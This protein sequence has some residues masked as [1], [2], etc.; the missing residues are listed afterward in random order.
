MVTDMKQRPN[1]KQEK[2]LA[3]QEAL[4]DAAE[5]LIA[6][7]G[8]HYVT[9]KDIVN[10]ANQKNPSVLQYHFKTMGGLLEALHLR[11][12]AQTRLHRSKLL[13]RA[14]IAKGK[15]ELRDLC[16]LMIRPALELARK[17][18]QYRAYAAAF[19]H[20]IAITG[21]SAFEVV[22]R[23]GGGSG[24]VIGKLLRDALPK[25][26]ETTFR[27]RMDLAMRMCSAAVSHH[28]RQKK[29]LSGTRAD[30]FTNTLID[31]LVG[32][33]SAAPFNNGNRK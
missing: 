19:G 18:K 13:E 17:D 12:V 20:E 9:I 28:V 5:T 29:P 16:G 27:A 8:P 2:S 21:D 22:S 7:K 24:F 11:R 3:T 25:L 15:L 6:A 30:F 31:A 26:D 14:L 10:A 33:L 23:T 1:R 32:V 4:M